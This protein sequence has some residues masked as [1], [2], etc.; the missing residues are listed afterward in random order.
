MTSIDVFDG[1]ALDIKL[2]YDMP[3]LNMATMEMFIILNTESGLKILV[4]SVNSQDEYLKHLDTFN[5]YRE[6]CNTPV[7][8]ISEEREYKSL[9]NKLYGRQIRLKNYNKSCI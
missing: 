6:L 4:S 7:K 8:S 1:P 3:M 2:I 5:R 9:Y